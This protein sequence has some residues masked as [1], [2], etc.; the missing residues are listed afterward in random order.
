VRHSHIL[1]R[2]TPPMTR[3]CIPLYKPVING[4]ITFWERRRSSTLITSLCSSYRHKGSCRMTT[5]R[6]G[7]PTCSS[8][9]STSSIRHGAQIMS[10]TASVDLP[11]LHSP[12]VLH[13]CGH[14][15]SEWPQLYQQD[16]D[17]ATTYQL[18]GIGMN[19]TDFHIQDEMLC[20]L[21]HLCV[22]AS[23]HAKMIWEAHYS[24]M[25]RTFWH[26][27]NCVILQKHFYW[28]KLQ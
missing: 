28:P 6:S 19:V 9:I 21:G 16:P 26:G 12:L 14:E 18:L 8:S 23:E 27:E 15:A 13:S 2:N 22:P 10:L 3:K 11:W 20:H 25:A 17:F 1:S 4:N 24:R 5:I 7:P